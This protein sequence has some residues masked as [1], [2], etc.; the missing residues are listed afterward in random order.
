MAKKPRTPNPPRPVQAPQRRD[1][2]KTR[3]SLDRRV[4]LGAVAAAVVIAAIVLGIVLTR[5]GG[6]GDKS[7]GGYTDKVDFAALPDLHAGPPPWDNG[8]SFL[9]GRLAGV[10]LTA[11]SQEALVFHIHQHLDLYVEGKKVDLPA[12]IGF[13][14]DGKVTELHTHDPTGLVHVESPL[15]RDYSLGQLFG[16]WGVW[17]SANRVG[18]S[19]GKVQWWVNGKK[20]AGNPADL[21]LKPH[22]E[23]VV[24]IGTPPTV[25][26]Q[27]YKF[28]EG[29]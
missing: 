8:S 24:A 16:E 12:G 1:A 27:T 29:T 13:T 23:I 5:G 7:S 21:V 11:L 22:Q 4:L 3:P 6:S 10:H 15:E 19:R 26:P 28:P 2:P 20:Q 17:L 9:A 18:D 25:V 14:A